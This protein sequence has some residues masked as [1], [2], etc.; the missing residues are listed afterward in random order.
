MN[1]LNKQAEQQLIIGRNS[2]IEAINSNS[3]QINKIFISDSFSSNEVKRQII[4]F[5][6]EKKI[7][8]SIV[9]EKKLNNISLNKN[10]QGIILSISPIKLLTVK[11]IL[12]NDSSNKKNV[13]SSNVILVANEIEDNH[14]LGAIIRTFAGIGGNKI[15]LTGKKSVGINST[16]VKTIAGTL[17]QI[18][19]ARA[20]NCSN[21][22]SELKEN[23]FWVIG[24][25]NSSNAESIYKV[26]FPEKVAI[27]IGNEHD[28]LNP[29]VKKNCDF[30]IKIPIS[31]T[32]NSL[33]VSV[34]F[35]IVLFENYR[36]N[37]FK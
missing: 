9:P 20:T 7:P 33:N 22:I 32:V 28:G 16:T 17:L 30:L 10:H 4:S 6:K 21:V 11:E 5:A 19:F 37:S 23:N 36:Q 15:I 13:I 12:K 2:A 1:A 29:L 31:E 35:G 24:T 34:A 3:I 25:D 8:F 27:V 14:N 26:S 18:Q